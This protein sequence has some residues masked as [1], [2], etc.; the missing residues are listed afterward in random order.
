MGSSNAW[1]S[2]AKGRP[3][4]PKSRLPRL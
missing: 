4:P 1:P 2:S 3:P